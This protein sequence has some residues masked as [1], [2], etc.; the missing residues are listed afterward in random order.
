MQFS[1]LDVQGLIEIINLAWHD[2]ESFP[3][4]I[5][6]CKLFFLFYWPRAHH[7]TGK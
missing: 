6:R 5:I 7:L 2:G 3:S 4:F 1:V